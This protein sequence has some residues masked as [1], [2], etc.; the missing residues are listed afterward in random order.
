MPTNVTHEY[1]EA[2]KKYLNSRTIQE[3]IEGLQ[4]MLKN[5]NKHKGTEKLE[6]QLKQKISKLKLQLEERSKKKKGSSKYS[7]KKEG[8]ARIVIVGTTNSGKSTLLSRIT[9]AK[10]EIADYEFTT[11]MPEQGV[12]DYKGVKLQVVEIPALTKN[13]YFKEEGPPLLSIIRDSDLIILTFR[14]E[15]ERKM[16]FE[17]LYL[18]DINLPIIYYNNENVEKLKELIWNNLDIIHVFTKMPGKKPSYPPIALKKGSLIK[19]LTEFVH[20]DFLKNFKYAR[21]WGKS[22]KHDGQKI[23]LNH[24]LEDG[25]IVEL[26]E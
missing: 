10:P 23:G 9:N 22:A 6:K 16:L 20:K 25:D 11:K 13:F 5:L 2:E 21:I 8:A 12:M 15:D 24:K 7:I 3:K 17:E 1:K 18:N 14:N 4:D 19:D 26:H